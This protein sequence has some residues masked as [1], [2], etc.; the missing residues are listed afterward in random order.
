MDAFGEPGRDQQ[1]EQSNHLAGGQNPH[2][3]YPNPK[4]YTNV[5]LHS[6]AICRSKSMRLAFYFPS[7]GSL[8]FGWHSPA[9]RAAYLPG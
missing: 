3:T 4:T 2:V 7:H 5:N 6:F 8:L 9:S 1:A